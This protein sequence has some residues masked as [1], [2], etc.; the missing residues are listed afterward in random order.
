MSWLESAEKRQRILL[1][2]QPEMPHENST[3]ADYV[4]CLALLRKFT[5]AY[6]KT[7]R[8]N[9][10]SDVFWDASDEIYNDLTTMEDREMLKTFAYH[11]PSEESLAKIT[12][13]REA[14][15]T[16]HDALQANGT[17]SRELSVAVTELETSAMWAIKS[18]VCNDPTSE[19]QT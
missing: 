11:K 5:D 3:F 19:A 6:E 1:K 7:N 13:L 8:W 17:K 18:V 16:L 10:V 14:Y 12:A 15:S 9:Q 4:R 2:N